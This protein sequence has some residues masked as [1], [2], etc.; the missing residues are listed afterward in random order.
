MSQGIIHMLQTIHIEHNHAEL[1]QLTAC[2]TLVYLL[3]CLNI[4]IIALCT[5]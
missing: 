4:C 5:G 2:N 1:L 3:L